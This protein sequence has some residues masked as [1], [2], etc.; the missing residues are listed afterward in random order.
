MRLLLL[1][2]LLLRRRQRDGLGLGL[3][4]RASH[5]GG[6][7]SLRLGLPRLHHAPLIVPELVRGHRLRPSRGERAP[8]LR[9]PRRVPGFVHGFDVVRQRVSRAELFVAP[10]VLARERALVGVRSDVRDEELALEELLPA[11]LVRARELGGLAAVRLAHVLREI[12]R[13]GEGF[14]AAVVETPELRARRRRRRRRVRGGVTTPEGSPAAARTSACSR[15]ISRRASAVDRPG[16]PP[17]RPSAPAEARWRAEGWWWWKGPPPNVPRGSPGVP[18]GPYGAGGFGMPEWARLPNPPAW[19]PYIDV[20]T[21]RLGTCAGAYPPA[22]GLDDEPPPGFG[23]RSSI[24]ARSAASARDR[25][26]ARREQGADQAR[27]RSRKGGRGGRTD[28]DRPPTRRAR[29]RPPRV[30]RARCA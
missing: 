7:I 1:G 24:V 29:T 5:R 2:E 14:V 30:A 11:S 9:A 6:Q 10:G 16:V 23:A 27:S 15:C 13:P 12:L 25:P 20:G 3:V 8:G 18:P 4:L 17:P 19:R 22:A 21:N 28:G 26:R